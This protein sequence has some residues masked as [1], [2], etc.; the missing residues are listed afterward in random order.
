MPCVHF[1][2]AKSDV[3]SCECGLAS[4]QDSHRKRVGQFCKI[5]PDAMASHL[6]IST[7]D[8]ISSF[9]VEPID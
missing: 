6:L 7:C 1:A 9:S 4:L 8:V 2:E 5:C 3:L